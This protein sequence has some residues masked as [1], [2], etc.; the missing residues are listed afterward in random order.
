MKA[1]R[2]QTILI[3]VLA[4]TSLILMSCGAESAANGSEKESGTDS[5]AIDSTGAQDAS[6][7]GP[8]GQGDAITFTWTMPN[9]PATL[10]TAVYQGN[11]TSEYA[12]ELAGRLFTWET[13]ALSGGGCEQF[14]DTVQNVA[15]QLVENFEISE[16][17]RTITMHLS[18]AV[19]TYGNE[20]S[21]EDVRWTLERLRESE[22]AGTARFLMN[23]MANYSDP[24]ITI[25]D[26]KTIEL[27]VDSPTTLD[28][29]L[30]T[31]LQFQIIDSVE[32]KR[33]TSTDDP[34]ATEWLSTH[35][36]TYGPWALESFDPE[37]QIV[38]VANE[39]YEGP[40]GN[41][42]RLIFTASPDASTRYQLLRTGEVDYASNLTYDQYAELSSQANDAI[43]IQSCVSPKRV[44][45]IL[46]NNEG[47]FESAE[48]RKAVSLAINRSALVEGAYHGFNAP[49]KYGLS[50][51]YNF[52]K[53]R[54][55][56]Y[57]FDPT[58]A[59]ELL[60]R[61]GIETPVSIDM[62]VSDHRPGPEA[63]S[64]AILIQNDLKSVGIDVNIKT[65]ASATQF[66]DLYHTGDYQALLYAEAPAIGS[67]YYTTFY[68]RSDSNVNSQGYDSAD[69][70]ATADAISQ[71]FDEASRHD[72]A[73]D[74]ARIVVDDPPSLYLVDLDYIRAVNAQY[75]GW[76]HTPDG[77]L[78]V[79][80]LDRPLT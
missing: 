22:T 5:F 26:S 1:R 17:S 29:A 54:N 3:A 68:S 50:A 9:V 64:M 61:A 18:D 19:S 15:G 33:H 62:H 49:S 11:Q 14:P 38:L 32:A 65:V 51:G 37:K 59:A 57:D 23:G 16:D 56:E 69:Y 21:A 48:A 2:A 12:T 27:R 73:T 39:H 4:T 20:L 46:N 31:Y 25:I 79:Y 8:R 67:P 36:A 44:N 70:D 58:E 40:R 72:L 30:L 53:S 80:L 34:Y 28:T 42:D 43:S 10:D 74:L 60:K 35:L 41:I 47:V 52:D 71:E 76:K 7:T 6:K 24:P 63:T 66:T 55:T 45:L 77:G 78:N 13:D 75:R